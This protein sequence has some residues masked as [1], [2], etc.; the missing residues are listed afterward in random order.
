MRHARLNWTSEMMPVKQGAAVMIALFGGWGISALYAVPFLLA[1][2][3]LGA[4]A[5]LALWCAV[6]L[7]LSLLLLRWLGRR[8]AETF[9]RL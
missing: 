9:S 8:G 2:Y 7:I 1:G 6:Y 3:R 4:P 5:Y